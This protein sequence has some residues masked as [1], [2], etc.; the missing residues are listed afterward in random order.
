MVNYSTI[1]IMLSFKELTTLVYLNAV[2]TMYVPSTI[3]EAYT[4]KKAGANTNNDK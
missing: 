2:S 4:F 1:L 3:L